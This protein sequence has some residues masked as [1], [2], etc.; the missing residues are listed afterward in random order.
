MSYHRPPDNYTPPTRCEQCHE[1]IMYGPVIG[2]HIW[3]HVARADHGVVMRPEGW[4]DVATGE[5]RY[6]NGAD[7]LTPN[8]A[9]AVVV[10]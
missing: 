7:R 8:A 9:P 10:G 4:W 5:T 6:G 1:V 2:G 3:R